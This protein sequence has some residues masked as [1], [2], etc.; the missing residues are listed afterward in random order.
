M[1][2]IRKLVKAGA[3]QDTGVNPAAADPKDPQ[4]MGVIVC[5]VDYNG[6]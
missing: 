1:E 2:K 6:L 3:A 4:F 5:S